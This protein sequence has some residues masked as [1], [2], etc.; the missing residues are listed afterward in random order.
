MAD[1][2]SKENELQR[3]AFE[4]YYGLGDKRSLRAVAETIGR[5]ERTVAGWSRVF[6]WVARVTQRNIENAQNNNEAKITAE[7]TDVRT[8]YRILINNLMA[9]FSKDI[10]QGKVKVKN[11]ND[12]ERLVKLDMLLMGEATERVERGGTQ[13]LSQ[14][15]KD[16]LDEIAQLMKSAKK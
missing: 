13:E 10:A 6:N 8:K 2:L 4:L 16:R 1:K 12:F 5:T 14:D 9:D 11:I 7:L 15:A 3:K